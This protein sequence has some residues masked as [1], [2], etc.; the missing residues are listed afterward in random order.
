MLTALLGGGFYWIKEL[1]LLDA[2]KLYTPTG[3]PSWVEERTF[4]EV[5]DSDSDSDSDTFQ[6]WP[7]KPEEFLPERTFEWTRYFYLV[8]HGVQY[9][10]G[11]YPNLLEG[12]GETY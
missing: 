7:L 12:T 3:A 1:T 10:N 4:S 6:L 2:R 5:S 11:S 9:E 8:V